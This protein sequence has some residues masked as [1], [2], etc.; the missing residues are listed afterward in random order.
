MQTSKNPE[1]KL[2][3]SQTQ[4]DSSCFNLFWKLLVCF[5][6]PST[7]SVAKRI[8]TVQG[9]K[10]KGAF[11]TSAKDLSALLFPPNVSTEVSGQICAADVASEFAETD[12]ADACE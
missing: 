4:L 11:Y 5:F 2:L 9:N 12:Q 7:H 6:L 3:C 1:T 10:W 8:Q